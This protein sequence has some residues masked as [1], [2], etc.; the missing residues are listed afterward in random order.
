MV[1]S[2]SV[3]LT[4]RTRCD[5]ARP[6][7]RRV[8]RARARAAPAAP[9][10]FRLRGIG[11]VGSFGP[12]GARV[13]RGSPARFAAPRRRGLGGIFGTG[14]HPRPRADLRKAKRGAADETHPAEPA[15]AR[16]NGR[17]QKAPRPPRPERSACEVMATGRA[18]RATEQPQRI[19]NPNRR[20]SSKRVCFPWVYVTTSSRIRRRPRARAAR[21]DVR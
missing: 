14:A 11:F 20:P 4:T 18:R 10:A 12:R 17:G 8:C 21:S 19:S 2:T 6:R 15:R 9:R 3:Q 7:H 5:R 1:Q 16:G 13:R